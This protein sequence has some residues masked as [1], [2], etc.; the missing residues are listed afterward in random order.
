MNGDIV[1]ERSIGYS[2][3]TGQY[4][5]S[6]AGADNAARIEASRDLTLNAGRDLLNIGGALQAGNN[7]TLTAGRDL[8]IAAAAEVDSSSGQQK[9]ARWSASQTTQHASDIAVGGNL[10]ADAGRDLAIIAS[11]VK[12][13]GN[14]AL[15]AAG[16][17]AISAAANESHSEFHRKGGSKKIDKEQNTVRQQAAVLEAGG[18]LS[19]E[20]GGNVLVTASQLKAGDEAYVYAGEQLALM[21]AQ[22][23]DY[24]LYD[25][26]KKGSFG[27]KKTQRDEV[28]TVRNVGSEITTGGDLTLISEGNQRYQVAKL[29]SGNDLTLDSGGA[30]T[31]EA[32]KDLQQESHEKSSTSLAWNSMKGKGKTDESVRQS[33]LTAQGEVVINAIDGLQIDIRH[34]DQHS[35]SQTID[36]MVTA[37]PQLAW[38]KDAEKRGDV[39]W[40]RVK[41]V[42]DSFKYDHSSLG[43]GAMLAIAIVVTVLT[44]GGASSMIG[45]AASAYAGSGTAMAAS[46][47]A[48]TSA[49]A[50]GATAGSIVAAGWGNVALTAVATSAASTATVS[51]IN[52]KGNLGAALKDITS[53]ENLKSYAL[54]GITAGIGAKLGYNPLNLKFD[55]NSAQVLAIKMSVD[56][57]V[58]TAAKGGSLSDNVVDAVV[59]TAISVGGA[60]GANQIGD[61]TIGSPTWTK[62]A[63]HA[64]FGGLLA[65]AMGG[66]FRTGA[67]AAGA[68]EVMVSVLAD[69]VLPEGSKI[70]PMGYEGA[71][72]RLLAYSQL[73]GVLA[74]SL[75]GGDVNVGAG[76]A[77]N[78]T[79]YNYL[80]HVE[81]A[82]L[83]E[84]L[85]K[86]KALGN[87][88]GV[89]AKFLE[90]HEANKAN[91]EK[92][93][94][95][96]VRTC[97][98]IAAEIHKAVIGFQEGHE[99]EL[100]PEERKIWGQF[101]ALNI[102]AENDAKGGIVVPTLE[103]IAVA[104]GLDP[105][106][107]QGQA[108]VLGTASLIA[109]KL[110]GKG[111]AGGAKGVDE[112]PTRIPS[113]V[114][115]RVNIAN[116][117]TET[118][119]LRDNGNPVSAG[120]D[121]VIDGHFNRE[122]SNSRSVFTI[123]PD[124]LKGIL[125]SSSVVK[126]P[127]AALPDGQFVRTVDVG[128]AIGT[129]T[130]KDGGAPT[131]VIKVFTDKAGNLIT[132]F[133]V[134]VGN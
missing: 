14:L 103:Q 57:L 124:E 113:R 60:L 86:C 106:S 108:A 22:N 131:S 50:S 28:T 133:P 56:A 125:Q 78:A 29:N 66:D 23:S 13:T 72:K 25:Y 87:C 134:K 121:H 114:Q 41:E 11:T 85:S 20:G 53:S 91:L 17:V 3:H 117:R 101:H 127:V 42:H 104:M 109:G 64:T 39:D 82:Q 54:S 75:T 62:V 27:A 73:V 30:I 70:D 94:Q 24:Y 43:Q 79:Q 71:T 88:E 55:V 33:Q 63:L 35:V 107:A 44:Y 92:I 46:G 123:A 16:E 76:V 2:E 84:E 126:S 6:Q 59:G 9:R 118:T 68:N 21:S 45:G 10:Q 99:H 58:S 89:G 48:T 18:D 96:D 4:S 119:P 83:N 74:A 81:M 90:K 102:D 93:C 34:L 61:A 116:G 122:I 1:N 49:V 100:G 115:S 80:T 47:I 52:N 128:R 12:A 110:T 120:F 98:S 132:T 95:V 15:S 51:V 37:D 31:F 69:S 32:V 19:V 26:K 5:W 129:T 105:L 111:G 77:A 36:A 7:A 65:E 112:V 38:L 130:L 97:M 40:Q 8:A 67:L